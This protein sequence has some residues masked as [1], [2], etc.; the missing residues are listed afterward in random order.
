METLPQSAAEFKVEQPTTGRLEDMG[1]P[2][3]VDVGSTAVTKEDHMASLKV[4]C[5]LGGTWV[6]RPQLAK[7]EASSSSPPPSKHDMCPLAQ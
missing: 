6:E 2:A 7:A 1:P 3:K 4:E 5:R